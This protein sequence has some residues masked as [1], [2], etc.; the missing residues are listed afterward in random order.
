MK[1][2]IKI[3]MQR[4]S[5]TV[6]FCVDWHAKG[7]VTPVKDQG[8]CASGMIFAVVGSIE[9]AHGIKTNKLISLSENQIADCSTNDSTS[10]F[11][12]PMDVVLQYIEHADGLEREEDYPYD[13]FSGKC[14]FN[15]SKV[16]VK[17]C[18]FN[19]TESKNET[20][21]QQAVATVGPVAALIDI[22]HT[23]IQLYKHGSTYSSSM[24]LNRRRRSL[25][26]MIFIQF[27]MNQGV[28]K[29]NSMVVFLSLVM[30]TIPVKIIGW[31]K[32]GNYSLSSDQIV[33][34]T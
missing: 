3:V 21:L 32:T 13:G 15:A 30:A 17:V 24:I 8:E 6:L 20:A 22:S 5:P 29:C 25:R 10:C 27:T 7:D 9:S 12:V 26:I 11:G 16:A 2:S 23:S 4:I 28:H 14:R 34:P 19:F 1:H 18:G 31:L 33:N